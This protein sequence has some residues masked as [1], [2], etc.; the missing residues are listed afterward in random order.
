MKA[1]NKFLLFFAIPLAVL[2]I[3]G[4]SAYTF[5]QPVAT[6]QAQREAVDYLVS[7]TATTS[8]TGHYLATAHELAGAASS[9]SVLTRYAELPTYAAEPADPL[10]AVLQ[11]G[12]LVFVNASSSTTTSPAMGGRESIFTS[13]VQRIF[14]QG[15]LT[16]AVD[17][18][19]AYGGCTLTLKVWRSDDLGASWD[20]VTSTLLTPSGTHPS[21]MRCAEAGFAFTVPTGDPG[22]SVASGR[23]YAV[24]V[25][26]GGT[27]DHV[28]DAGTW[29]TP[30]WIFRATPIPYS[31]GG[32][33]AMT[34]RVAITAGSPVIP[35]GTTIPSPGYSTVPRTIA[36]D[37]TVEPT[38][39][40][41]EAADTTHASALSGVQPAGTYVTHCTGGTSALYVPNRH[42]DGVLTIASAV[43]V[44][45][46]TRAIAVGA[47]IP[48]VG[49][50]TT[51]VTTP[52]YW[53]PEPTCA[54]YDELDD[55]FTTP[56][57]GA[58]PAGTYVTHCTGGSFGSVELGAATD[59]VLAIT[60]SVA[61]TA[62]SRTIS[63]ATPVTDPGY[64]S[65]PAT[66]ATDWRT[67]PQCAVYAASDTG[68]LSRLNGTV[69]S[70]G[71]YV[72][73]CTGGVI[74]GVTIGA[75]T[76]GVLTV[77]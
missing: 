65:S 39:A 35:D 63:S 6:L 13:A 75:Y 21:A 60:S 19:G 77:T 3:A 45:A 31:P 73:H 64:T 14:V 18:I 12:D 47:V 54:V 41:Y 69:V 72:T 52:T 68:F 61:V 28:P 24:T 43:Q 48:N 27:L 15:F 58:Q 42:S 57:T 71:T 70:S 51:P 29:P 5:S 44:T 62:G 76:N 40:V 25:E 7:A 59:G 36:A 33:V 23:Q 4:S 46:D 9:Q 38:C 49:Y 32:Q 50:S 26:A 37:W 8:S 2:A 56:L 34:S 30:T 16:N 74:V 17:M 20:D 66:L 67:E 55:T 1:Q 53:A 22:D 10:A 11:P